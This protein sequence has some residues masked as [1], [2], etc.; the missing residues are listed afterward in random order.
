MVHLVLPAVPIAQRG[1]FYLVS[2]PAGDLIDNYEVDRWNRLKNP[3]GYQRKEFDDRI[4]EV[5][6]YLLNPEIVKVGASLIDQTPLVNVRG[7]ATF[8]DGKLTIDGDIFVVDGQHRI[9]GLREASLVDP[10]LRTLQ[11]PLA[12]LNVNK[13]TERARFFI[14]NEK[15]HKVDTGLAERQLL[16]V[17]PE[18]AELVKHKFDPKFVEWAVHIAGRLNDS[19]GIWKDAITVRGES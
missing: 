9:A 18:I 2:I 1:T 3:E 11:I 19:P 13:D 8:S 7:S 12:V 10:S 17:H 16:K 15:S 5:K 4:K 14:I 6:N